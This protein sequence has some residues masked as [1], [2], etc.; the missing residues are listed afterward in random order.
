MHPTL[1]TIYFH[2]SSGLQFPSG[3]GV[4]PRVYRFDIS[5]NEL[6]HSAMLLKFILLTGIKNSVSFH[7]FHWGIRFAELTG[8]F[9]LLSFFSFFIS[10]LFL[11]E[12]WYFWKRTLRMFR[13]MHELEN[14]FS[15]L[16]YIYIFF[17][18]FLFI[19]VEN[20]KNEN[21]L[22]NKVNRFLQITSGYQNFIEKSQK[23]SGLYAF[24]L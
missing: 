8:Q 18:F 12:N 4:V 2:L 1:P 9:D 24:Y 5:N 22:A 23:Y 20:H 7:P 15:F 13:E 11:E 10:K 16:F 21:T 19:Q 14:H 3:T 17:P 6:C